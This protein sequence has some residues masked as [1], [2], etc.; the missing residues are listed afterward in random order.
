[1]Y[2]NAQLILDDLS[3]RPLT[4][5]SMPQPNRAASPSRIHMY[6][7][8]KHEEHKMRVP[9]ILA[10]EKPDTQQSCADNSGSMLL[11]AAEEAITIDNQGDFMPLL[12]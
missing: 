3:S 6:N 9:F 7:L 4:R 11:F 2:M 1:M 12:S 10:P 8:Q 5:Q